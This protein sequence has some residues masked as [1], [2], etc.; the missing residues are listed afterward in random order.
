VAEGDV[1][2]GAGG[3]EL[4]DRRQVTVKEALDYL[5]GPKGERF[6]AVLEHGSLVVEIYAPRGHDPQTPHTRDEVYIVI[7]GS[8]YFV[9]GE[10]REPFGAGDLLFVPAGITHRFEDFT[11]DL[12]VWVIFYGP[13]G[14]ELS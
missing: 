3:G 10:T 1:E 5:P 2:K 7:G 12:K 8:G 11:D 13:E 14:G 6:A 4:E 9:N